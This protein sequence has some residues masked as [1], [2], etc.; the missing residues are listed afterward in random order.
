MAFNLIKRPQYKVF[1]VKA[2]HTYDIVYLAM[3]LFINERH[4]LAYEG[5][6]S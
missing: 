2:Y 3:S 4:T 6:N 1:E 5:T